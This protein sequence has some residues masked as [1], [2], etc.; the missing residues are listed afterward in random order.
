VSVTCNSDVPSVVTGLKET[1]IPQD[2]VTGGGGGWTPGG[3]RSS[4]S[5]QAT[6]MGDKVLEWIMTVH[7][8]S[9]I[10]KL[11]PTFI[12]DCSIN[13]FHTRFPYKLKFIRLCISRVAS[14][15]EMIWT[16]N[17]SRWFISLQKFWESKTGQCVCVCVWVE[18]CWDTPFVKRTD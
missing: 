15:S 9:K 13:S 18:G 16:R 11:Y 5:P 3:N 8:G 2:A 4:R 17:V 12:I 10:Q 6:H 7:T 14:N 1:F